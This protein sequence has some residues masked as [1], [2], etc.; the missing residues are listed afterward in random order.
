MFFKMRKI[1]IISILLLSTI[2]QLNSQEAVIVDKILATVN[3]EIITLSDLKIVIHF[4]LYP[5]IEKK[6]PEKY[7]EKM[8]EQKV[9]R[10]KVKRNF[11][12]EKEILEEKKRLIRE[13]GSEENLLGELAKFGLNWNDLEIYLEEKI[14]FEKVIK[15]RFQ[16]VAPITL[17][18]IEKYY[19]EKYVPEEKKKNLYPKSLL[20]VASEIES[21]IVEHKRKELI[22]AWLKE[23]K[24]ELNIEIKV[25]NFKN[26]LKLIKQ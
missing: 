6:E 19:Y 24:N 9:V 21:K 16:F 18:E 4:N 20:E 26:L 5:E 11:S 10:E 14:Y 7:I 13:F 17:D 2:I 12:L 15:D 25:K 3:D 8:I 23:L 22:S 1:T